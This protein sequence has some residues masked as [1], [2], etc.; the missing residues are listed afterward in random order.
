[1]TLQKRALVN[2]NKIKLEHPLLAYNFLYNHIYGI[3]NIDPRC[4]ACLRRPTLNHSGIQ[5]R[6]GTVFRFLKKWIIIKTDIK[7][8]NMPTKKSD[9]KKAAKKAKDKLQH[10]AVAKTAKDIFGKIKN[11]TDI[12]NKKVDAWQKKWLAVPK[13]RTKYE[14]LKDAPAVVGEELFAMTND[15]IDFVQR[16]EGGK[17][18]VFKSLKE[19]GAAFLHH[20]IE[21][22]QKKGEEAGKKAKEVKKSAKK[23]AKKT[24]SATKK[25]AK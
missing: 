21:Y 22:L 8:K 4:G 10:N 5:R 6:Q 25:A 3:P 15:I 2:Y 13:N 12:D 1:M 9:P 14:H 24:K 7:H 18:H 23:K 11:K 19:K 16:E 17:S 20:P